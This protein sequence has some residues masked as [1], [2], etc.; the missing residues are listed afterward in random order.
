[1]WST[2]HCGRPAGTLASIMGRLLCDM[3][4][5]TAKCRGTE[6]RRTHYS[7]V[8]YASSVLQPGETIKAVGRL[9][10]IVFV[11][12]FLLAL[13]GAALLLYGYKTQAAG[14][15]DVASVL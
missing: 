6:A 7:P 15:G 9:H 11:R 2:I 3:P 14:R 4:S 12:G 1:M 10:W 8:S 5:F 13:I